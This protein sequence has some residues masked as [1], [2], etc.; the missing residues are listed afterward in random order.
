MNHAHRNMFDINRLAIA[1][2]IAARIEL[3]GNVKDPRLFFPIVGEY[4][5]NGGF[6][7]MGTLG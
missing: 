2:F 6:G 5:L 1:R 7:N 4:Q 3:G